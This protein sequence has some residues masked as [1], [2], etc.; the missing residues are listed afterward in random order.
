MA[1]KRLNVLID[2]EQA[3]KLEALANEKALPISWLVRRAIQ[4]LLDSLA[5]TDMKGPKSKAA[6]APEEDPILK[7]IGLF[8]AKPLSSRQIDEEL[9][10][11]SRERAS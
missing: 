4:L 6:I 8:A 1:K 7:V 2:R 11:A 3:E 9:Y 10:A 5:A